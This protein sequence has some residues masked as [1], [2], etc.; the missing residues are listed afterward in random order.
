[1]KRKSAAKRSDGANWKRHEKN[2]WRRRL[3]GKRRKQ[4]GERTFTKVSLDEFITLTGRNVKRFL[5][6]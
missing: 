6:F 3:R 1:M 5:A 2:D 4:R